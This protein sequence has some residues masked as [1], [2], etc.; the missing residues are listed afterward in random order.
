MQH[1]RDFLVTPAQAYRMHRKKKPKATQ[2][3]TGIFRNWHALSPEIGG[4]WRHRWFF[5]FE[6]ASENIYSHPPPEPEKS[7]ATMSLESDPPEN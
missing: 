1:S 6:N 3:R 5:F 4:G 7:V 2:H